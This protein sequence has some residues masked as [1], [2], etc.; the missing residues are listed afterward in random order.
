MLIFIA[1]KMCKGNVVKNKVC[2]VW[3]DCEQFYIQNIIAETN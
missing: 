3:R 2:R 1:V